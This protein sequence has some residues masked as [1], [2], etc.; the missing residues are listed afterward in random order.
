[1]KTTRRKT[2]LYDK[3]ITEGAEMVGVFLFDVIGYIAMVMMRLEDRRLQD[4]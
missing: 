1:M 2:K 4:G 3:I